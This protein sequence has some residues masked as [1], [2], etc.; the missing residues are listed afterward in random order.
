MKK[1]NGTGHSSK[2]LYSAL[3]FI[4]CV[5]FIDYSP[6]VP[7]PHFCM[8]YDIIVKLSL[9]YVIIPSKIILLKF[10]LLLPIKNIIYFCAMIFIFIKRFTKIFIIIIVIPLKIII[11]C[12]FNSANRTLLY[13]IY[14]IL[15]MSNILW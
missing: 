3:F 4:N 15:I 1:K 6:P 11:N 7:Y 10:D 5:H 2:Q 14:I 13:F 9:L 8:S 12:V